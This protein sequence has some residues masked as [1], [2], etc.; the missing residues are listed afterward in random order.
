AQRPLRA[1]APQSHPPAATSNRAR[2]PAPDT[3]ALPRE[4][5]RPPLPPRCTVWPAPLCCAPFSE[6]HQLVDAVER[7]LFVTL[8]QR[9]IVK[10]G[11][12]EVVHRALQNQHRLPDV[13]QL[14]FAFADAMSTE[15]LPRLA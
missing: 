8:G 10:H 1:C 2:G 12:D 11:L 6:P 3:S 14:R 13:Q 7:R 4:S 15:N 5:R 9:W